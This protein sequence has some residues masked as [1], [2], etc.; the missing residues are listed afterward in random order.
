MQVVCVSVPTAEVSG[1]VVFG[2]IVRFPETLTVP[3]PP[4][5]VI[6]Q[7]NVPETV[8]VP[9]IVTSLLFHVPVIPAGKPVKVAPV[10]PVVEYLMVLIGELTHLPD[11]EIIPPCALDNKIIVLI[12]FT[13]IVVVAVVAHCPTAGVKV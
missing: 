3:H 11:C 9:D 10:A 7:A 12:G 2:F 1:K 13:T 8:G 4:V 6:I 5:S